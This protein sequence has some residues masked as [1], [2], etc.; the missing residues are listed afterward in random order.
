M[1]LF[2]FFLASACIAQLTPGFRISN[3]GGCSP[4]TVIFKNTTSGASAAAVYSWD[5]GNG[6]KS[7]LKDPG[8][9]FIDAKI[10]TITLIVTDSNKTSSATQTITVYP[11]PVVDF[12]A[13]AQ[14]GY[15]PLLV[16]FTG[17][18]SPGMQN[19]FW[20]FGDG[21]TASGAGN[22]ITHKLYCRE[23]PS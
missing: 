13:S 9:V 19:Y 1:L 6:N 16:T 8:A 18:T 3:S 17:N 7:F 12:S 22:D 2:Y 21:N 11:K 20:D 14:K 10:Y 23:V 15:G 4:I 5:F